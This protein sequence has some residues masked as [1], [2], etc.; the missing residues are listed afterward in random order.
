MVGKEGIEPPQSK[1]A[2][3]QSAELTTCSTYPCLPCTPFGTEI[4]VVKGGHSVLCC[5]SRRR[6]SNPEPVVYKTTALPIEL[7]RRR[8]RM[9]AHERANLASVARP[10]ARQAGSSGAGGGASG[11]RSASSVRPGRSSGG[12]SRRLGRRLVVGALRSGGMSALVVGPSPP[13]QL[14]SAAHRRRPCEAV[15]ASTVAPASP[16][17]SGRGSPRRI[18]LAALRPRAGRA[19][20]PPRRGTPS[21]P[22]RR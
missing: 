3:L 22:P 2:D 15:A 20:R 17:T 16:S 5:W 8:R 12:C 7:R 4:P 21:R 6:D 14:P 11:S 13:V 1:T 19:G 18:G 10:A 9:V